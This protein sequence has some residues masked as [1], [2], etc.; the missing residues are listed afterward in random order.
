MES[1][2]SAFLIKAGALE[3]PFKKEEYLSKFNPIRQ[4][5]VMLFTILNY[6]RFENKFHQFFLLLDL[7]ACF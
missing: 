4:I 6:I 2:K 1:E 3:H 5:L 7:S